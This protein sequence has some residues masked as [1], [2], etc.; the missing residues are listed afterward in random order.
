MASIKQIY[1]PYHMKHY[2][3]EDLENMYNHIPQ[4]DPSFRV[5]KEMFTLHFENAISQEQLITHKHF[6][7]FVLYYK[8]YL[9]VVLDEKDPDEIVR[10]HNEHC[11]ANTFRV[12]KKKEDITWNIEYCPIKLAVVSGMTEYHS[13]LDILGVHAFLED[14]CSSV[15]SLQIR[16][17]MK[18]IIDELAA[19]DLYDHHDSYRVGL[20]LSSQGKLK[21]II[22]H[23]SDYKSKESKEWGF[24]FTLTENRLTILDILEKQWY[25]ASEYNTIEHAIW[26]IMETESEEEEEDDDWEHV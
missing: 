18:N 24:Y 23:D 16:T 10:L 5:I 19:R 17:L 9:Q 20:S 8:Q 15:W 14:T 7:D 21:V 2:S 4:D 12:L 3:S 25:L 26:S 1:F 13:R 22:W 6:Q 11:L